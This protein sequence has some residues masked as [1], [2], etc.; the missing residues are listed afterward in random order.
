MSC[1]DTRPAGR[2]LCPPVASAARGLPIPRRANRRHIIDGAVNRRFHP[3]LKGKQDHDR[4][5]RVYGVPIQFNPIGEQHVS[6]AVRAAR[7]ETN[8]WSLGAQDLLIVSAFAMWSAVLGL[9]P[10][11]LRA[12]IL[13]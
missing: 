10:L 6:T 11:L 3:R 1:R 4:I 8:R 7:L 5:L 9:S 2:L 12:L 13:H